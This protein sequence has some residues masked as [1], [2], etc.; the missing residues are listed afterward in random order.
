MSDQTGPPF[1]PEGS[2]G[3]EKRALACLEAAGDL[4]GFKGQRALTRAQTWATL[5]LMAAVREAAD[6]GV[7]VMMEAGAS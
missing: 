6:P 2:Y 7:P 1:A 5:A 3:Y 4:E